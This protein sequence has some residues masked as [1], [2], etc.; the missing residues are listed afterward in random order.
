MITFKDIFSQNKKYFF[1]EIE[2]EKRKNDLYKSNIKKQ[3]NHFHLL[4]LKRIFN[5][6][7]QNDLH[8]PKIENKLFGKDRHRL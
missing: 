2:Y 5:Y 1:V 6:F 4:K 8:L 3:S 7:L